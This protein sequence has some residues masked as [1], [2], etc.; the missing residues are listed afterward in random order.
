[1]PSRQLTRTLLL[2][3]VAGAIAASPTASGATT[4]QDHYVPRAAPPNLPVL[5]ASDLRAVRRAEAVEARGRAYHLPAGAPYSNAEWSA[6]ALAGSPAPADMWWI[7]PA[8][9]ASPS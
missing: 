5:S 9:A 8:P 2:A 1:M 6:F 7:T 3:L 4:M